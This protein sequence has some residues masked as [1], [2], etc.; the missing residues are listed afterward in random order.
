MKRCQ[1]IA[2]LFL[3]ITLM[4]LFLAMGP[5][6]AA[7][8]VASAPPSTP[9]FVEI[10]DYIEEQMRALCIPGLALGIVQ[11]NQIVHLKGFGVAGPDGRPVTPQT[12]FQLASLGKP[13]TG[14]AVMQLVEVGKLDLDA[15]IQRCLPWFRVADEPASAL[16]TPRHLLYHTRGLPGS[17][18]AEYAL[19]GDTRPDALEMRMRELRSVQLNRPVGQTYEYSNAGYMLLGLLIQAISGQSYEAYMHDHVFALLQMRQTF[20]DWEEARRHGAATGH[21]FWFGVPMPGQLAIDRAILPAG[22]HLS[23]SVEDATHFL[24]AQLNDGRFGNA[25][26]LSPA[27]IA[28]MQRP[29]TPKAGGDEFDAM[30]WSVGSVGGATAIYKGGDNPD[31]KTQMIF[32]PERRL[33]LVL[34]MNMNRLFDSKLGD[35]RIPMLAYNAAELLVGQA[36]TTFSFSRTS[37][38]LYTVL[39]LAVA[40]QAAGMARTMILLRSWRN[41]P[42]QHPYGR[43]AIALHIA[44]PLLLNLG[45]G[46]FALVVVPAFFGASLA[47]LLYLVPDFSATLLASGAVAVIWAVVRTL[48]I[49]ALLRDRPAVGVVA[50]LKQAA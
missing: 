46:L 9:D 33:G 43:T 38:L 1:M 26:I 10:D 17:V 19:G 32:F 41:Q 18:G 12:P 44:L 13:M 34:L 29:I 23:G 36:P 37:T 40:V 5:S 8:Q 50:V 15:P 2:R 11:D 14:V 7:A 6:N 45:W 42:T 49:L 25:A 47:F 27:G 3:A 28:A 21:R 4:L 16:I 48:L 31:F 22:G 39:L 30:D 20:T 24:I 35:V